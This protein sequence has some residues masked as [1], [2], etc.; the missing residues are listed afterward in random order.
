MQDCDF[1]PRWESQSTAV[2]YGN[3]HIDTRPPASLH[4]SGTKRYQTVLYGYETPRYHPPTH[5]HEK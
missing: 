1:L 3:F 5:T 4:V 2:L